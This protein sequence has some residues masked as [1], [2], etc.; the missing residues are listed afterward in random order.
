MDGKKTYIAAALMGVT[1]I[2]MFFT[3]QI[4]TDAFIQQLLAAIA[5]SGLRHAI[6]T[7]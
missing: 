2:F 6:A 4:G 5:V 3:Q 7:K 1:A